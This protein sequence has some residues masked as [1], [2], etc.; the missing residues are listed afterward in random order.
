MPTDLSTAAASTPAPTPKKTK[1]TKGKKAGSRAASEGVAD[2]DDISKV[3]EEAEKG[4][5]EDTFKGATTLQERRFAQQSGRDGHSR[6]LSD[7]FYIQGV[8]TWEVS[9]C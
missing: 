8:K 6:R 1:T 3:K 7:T 9:E 4:V 5:D 2:E